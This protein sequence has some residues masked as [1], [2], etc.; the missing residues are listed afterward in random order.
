MVPHAQ[1]RGY[2]ARSPVYAVSFWE[3][4]LCGSCPK[5]K[6]GERLIVAKDGGTNYRYQNSINAF[7]FAIR[8][9]KEKALQKENADFFALTP[10]GRALLKKRGKTTGGCCETFKKV[11]ETIV[12]VRQNLLKKWFKTTS[13]YCET[14][15]QNLRL[16]NK[17]K[18]VIIY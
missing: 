6:V 7:S 5:E 10:R 17:R 8:G 14:V 2:G 11:D 18:C 1:W 13:G 3:L 16:T 15:Y 9:T 12:L 4:F